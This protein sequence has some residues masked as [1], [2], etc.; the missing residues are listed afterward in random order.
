MSQGFFSR[1]KKRFEAGWGGK[2][3]VLL[4]VLL[5]AVV[6]ALFY[7]FML[8]SFFQEHFQPWVVKINAH[9][10]SF[11]L[12]LFGEEPSAS[13]AVLLSEKASISI[14]RGCDALVPIFLFISAIVAFPAKW[15]YKLSGIIIGVAL[16]FILNIIRIISLFWVKRFWPEAF[17]MMHLEV[18][19]VLFIIIGILLWVL[20]MQRVLKKTK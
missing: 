1:I 2:Y 18:W 13:G 8:T 11:V 5:F 14:K 15:K 4:F 17:D 3:P 6:M 7:G 16:L 10:S 9:I 19:Q 12:N 20:W